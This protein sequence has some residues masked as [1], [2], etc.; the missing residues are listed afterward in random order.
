MYERIWHGQMPGHR[1]GKYRDREVFYSSYVQTY[2]NRDVTD[3]IANVDKLLF[4][5]FIRAAACRVGQLLNVHDIARDVGVSD[6]TARRWLQVL[7]KSEVVFFLR[8]YSNNLLKRT[9]K[10]PNLFFFRYGACCLPHAVLEP[11][12]PHERSDQRSDP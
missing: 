5:D 11:G 12:N 6:D 10:T 3:M 7:E 4:A 8:P 9:V 1:S 2:I